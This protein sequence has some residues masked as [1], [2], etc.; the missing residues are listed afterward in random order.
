MN[1][2]KTVMEIFDSLTD[3]QKHYVYD[4]VGQVVGGFL[5]VH[6][7]SNYIRSRPD[8]TNEQKEI[9]ICILEKAD[10]NKEKEND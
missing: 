2:T 7:A 10:N 3:K 5:S 9:V 4:K 8:F 6:T 1:E